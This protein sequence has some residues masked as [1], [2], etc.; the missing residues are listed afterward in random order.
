M[1][2]WDLHSFLVSFGNEGDYLEIYELKN[3][4]EETH[5]AIE[6]IRGSL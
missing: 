2:K 5:I 6:A 3:F 4:V 1:P